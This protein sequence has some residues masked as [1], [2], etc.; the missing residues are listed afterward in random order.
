MPKLTLAKY[1]D[2]IAKYKARTHPVLRWLLM[3]S[4]YPCMAPSRNFTISKRNSSLV[5]E[6]RAPG[7]S[8]I[9][10]TLLL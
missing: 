9:I 8:A 3:F 5:T 7:F 6:E 1:N 10:I 2:G 4:Q